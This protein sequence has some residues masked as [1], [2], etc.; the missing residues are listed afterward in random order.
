M[1]VVLL[2]MLS[3]AGIIYCASNGYAI[4][5]MICMACFGINFSIGMVI[6]QWYDEYLVS[7]KNKV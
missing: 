7:V 6:E 5:C 4:C 3:I 1:S 2:V